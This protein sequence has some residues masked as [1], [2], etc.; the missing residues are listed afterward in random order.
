MTELKEKLEDL[1]DSVME[2]PKKRTI[3]MCVLS[4]LVGF[5]VAQL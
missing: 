2:D 3:A 4:F 5:L 1:Y